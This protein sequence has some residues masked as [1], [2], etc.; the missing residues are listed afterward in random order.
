[1]VRPERP[2]PVSRAE[3]ASGERVGVAIEFC[4]EVCRILDL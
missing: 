4:A 2:I 3:K 1:M